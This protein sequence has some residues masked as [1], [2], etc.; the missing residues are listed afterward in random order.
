MAN[1][2]MTSAIMANEMIPINRIH[3]KKFASDLYREMVTLEVA[4]HK[5]DI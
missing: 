4:V 1:V 3:H 5:I 2:V